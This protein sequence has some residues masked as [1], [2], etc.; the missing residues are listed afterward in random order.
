MLRYLLLALLADRPRYGYEL[1]TA[2]EELLG[3][4]WTLNIGQIYSTLGRLEEDALVICEVVQQD[5]LPDRKVYSLTETGH[6]ELQRWLEEDIDSPVRLR[7][8]F[9]FKGV[10]QALAGAVDAEQLIW[11]QRE[12]RLAAMGELT[13]M[14]A[15][16]DIEPA[17]AL[18]LDGAILRLQADLRWL[19]LYEDRLKDLEGGQK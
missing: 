7:D 15:S 8:E 16:A 14:R 18:L 12:A 2:F 1:K 19:D 3:G 11:K 5:L 9:F 4:T 10:V 6:K 17:T 13:R